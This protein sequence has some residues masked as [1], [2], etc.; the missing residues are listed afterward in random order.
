MGAAE[1]IN[2]DFNGSSDLRQPGRSPLAEEKL[3]YERA[4][5]LKFCFLFF[6]PS[7]LIEMGFRRSPSLKVPPFLLLF[8]SPALSILLRALLSPLL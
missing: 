8:I 7:S 6:T 2:I 4:H 1:F 3:D 5:A